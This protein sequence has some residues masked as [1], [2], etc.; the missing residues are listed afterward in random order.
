V[1]SIRKTAMREPPDARKAIRPM[2]AQAVSE[3][4]DSSANRRCFAAAKC[5]KS[6]TFFEF[7]QADWRGDLP[8]RWGDLPRLDGVFNP[9]KFFLVLDIGCKHRLEKWH[10]HCSICALST[11]ALFWKSWPRLKALNISQFNYLSI[12]NT[13]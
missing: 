2:D 12:P 5:V 6:H 11:P 13:Q 7:E 10:R 3:T 9:Q 1:E 8:P 4:D